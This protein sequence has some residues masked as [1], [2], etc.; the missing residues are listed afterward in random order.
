MYVIWYIKY[1]KR[2]LKYPISSLYNIKLR[3]SL[4]HLLFIIKCFIFIILFPLPA[5]LWA[6]NMSFI[7]YCLQQYTKYVNIISRKLFDLIDTKFRWI[8]RLH[9]VIIPFLYFTFHP[10]SG[11][12]KTPETVGVLIKIM[13]DI[14]EAEPICWIL[15]NKS[16]I[17][18]LCRT[19]WIFKINVFSQNT[20]DSCKN[21]ENVLN[22]SK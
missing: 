12:V 16:W 15:Q 4:P 10:Y 21:R 2:F 18:Q 13:F 3:T 5:A 22:K 1:E 11:C 6:L 9:G 20:P 7:L 14:R 17:W 8:T 19:I